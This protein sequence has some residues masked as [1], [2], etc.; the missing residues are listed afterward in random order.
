[1]LLV[2]PGGPFWAKKDDGAWS[3]PKG[4]VDEGEEPRACALRELEEE[5]G[6][7]L[8]LTAEDLIELGSVRQK[9]GKMVHCWAAEGD[10]DPAELRSNTFTM[11]WPPRSGEGARVPRGRPGRVVRHPR[12][13][14]RR[15]TPRRPSSS[16][17]CGARAAAGTAYTRRAMADGPDPHS[18]PPGDGPSGRAAAALGAPARR[19]RAQRPQ[20][21]Q[22]DRHRPRGRGRRRGGDGRRGRERG[23][24][25]GDRAGA[26]RAR[27]SRRR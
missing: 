7:G 11:E 8:G 26:A 9:G 1:M 17:G 12:R 4:E 16:I 15:S 10:F 20:R 21:R 2:H 14:G 22:G 24:R 25:T 18:A 3:M 5:L 23:G 27:S 13:R 19:R 6:S